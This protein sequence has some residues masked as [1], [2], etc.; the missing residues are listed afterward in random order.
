MHQNKPRVDIIREILEAVLAAR[1]DSAFVA[2]LLRQYRERGSLSRK[3]LEGLY[4]KATRIKTIPPARL[5]T[6]E[7]ILHKKPTRYRSVGPVLTGPLVPLD[8]A[9]LAILQAILDKY[10]Q[11]KRVKY[12][13]AK[14]ENGEPLTGADQAEV[15][16]FGKLL[17]GPGT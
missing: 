9:S 6:L 1:P 5:A 4:G 12:L 14:M 13:L 10:P 17:L 11:H 2:S 15:H 7:A 3:Q 16:K 8:G